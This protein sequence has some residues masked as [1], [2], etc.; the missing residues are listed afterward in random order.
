MLEFRPPC[1]LPN[2]AGLQRLGLALLLWLVGTATPA[3]SCQVPDDPFAPL[4]DARTLLQWHWRLPDQA[5]AEAEWEPELFWQGLLS[6]VHRY[7]QATAYGEAKRVA[8]EMLAR[9]PGDPEAERY[10]LHIEA[11]KPG[12]EARVVEMCQQW[13]QRHALQPPNQ[14]QE[15]QALLHR[16]QAFLENDRNMQGGGWKSLGLPLAAAGLVFALFLTLRR[17]TA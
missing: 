12:S 3:W 2:F 14:I 17:S 11:S 15:V 13:L 6:Q 5:V 16:Y 1:R 7:Y 8:G 4:T 10:L 9:S